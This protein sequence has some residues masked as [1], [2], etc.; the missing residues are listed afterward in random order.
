MLLA[1]HRCNNPPLRRVSAYPALTSQA[2]Q[3]LAPMQQSSNNEGPFHAMVQGDNISTDPPLPTNDEAKD[4]CPVLNPDSGNQVRHSS[5][6]KGLSLTKLRIA[7]FKS[8][9]GDLL[10]ADQSQAKNI[11]MPVDI[12]LKDQMLLLSSDVGDN[13][14]PIAEHLQQPLTRSKA[15]LLASTTHPPYSSQC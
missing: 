4:C 10:V 8:G 2:S 1:L 14:P 12:M 9:V 6:A 5:P 11:F 7:S 13:I 3:H 15:K